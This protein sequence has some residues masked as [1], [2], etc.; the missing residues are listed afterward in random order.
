MNYVFKKGLYLQ[1]IIINITTF[2]LLVISFALETLLSNLSCKNLISVSL[3]LFLNDWS[4]N[5]LSIHNHIFC[6]S[7]VASF[8]IKSQNDNP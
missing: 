4:K 5:N 1:L 7:I 6:A 2:W 8:L 3:V